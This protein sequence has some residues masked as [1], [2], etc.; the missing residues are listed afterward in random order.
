[1]QFTYVYV[2]LD[3]HYMVSDET[4]ALSFLYSSSLNFLNKHAQ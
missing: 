4:A 2:Q 3:V 1:M